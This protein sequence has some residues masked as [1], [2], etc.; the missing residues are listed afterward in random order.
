M[1][2]HTNDEGEIFVL[3]F[4]RGGCDGLGLVAPVDDKFYAGARTPSLR[5]ASGGGQS[6]LAIKQSLT[7]A[8]FRF[9]NR[10]G[11]LHE[12]YEDGQLALIHACGLTN[13]TRSHFEAMELIEKGLVKKENTAKGWLSRY[14][15]QTE[16]KGTLP[17][18]AAGG[19][20]PLSF[21]GNNQAASL[22][23][24]TDYSLYSDPRALGILKSIY[25]EDKQ[26][27]PTALRTLE[28]IQ[29]LDKKGASKNYR[30]SS[31]ANYPQGWHVEELSRSLKMLA[32]LIKMDVGVHVA[33]VD[34]G[35]WDTHENQAYRFPNLVKGLSDA[36]GAF[37]TDVYSYNKRL[38]VV[39]M[40]EFGRRLR[41]NRS[42]G[43]D[44][45]YGNVMM[46][47]GGNVNGRNMYGKWPGLA[48]EQLNNRVDLQVTTDYRAVLGEVL[49][50]RLGV[51]DVGKVFPDFEMGDRLGFIS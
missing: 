23:G 10:A 36:I 35:G 38:T 33:T 12:L 4:L 16:V 22:Y 2:W 49:Q 34:Y 3:V 21:L 31:G 44:H 13:G 9:H 6:G 5:I 48:T 29:Y 43:T 18:I 40:S 42:G 32:Q 25:K 14:L 7:D 26:L 17:A 11:A 1:P 46:V 8:D 27:G 39:V 30:P 47:L 24:L 45:G 20:M 50:Q 15:D 41:T 28:T 51:T 19:S 37:Y